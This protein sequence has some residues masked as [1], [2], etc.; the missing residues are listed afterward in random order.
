[1]PPTPL[2][3]LFE[4][5][6]ADN[7]GESWRNSYKA[8]CSQIADIRSG[9]QQLTLDFVKQAWTARNFGPAS[10][11]QARVGEL[12]FVAVAD[13]LLRIT[14]MV[15]TDPSPETLDNAYAKLQQAKD[16]S[17]IGWTP[18]VLT[19]RLM[20]AAAPTRYTSVVYKKFYEPLHKWLR[21]EYGLDIPDIGNWANKDSSMRTSLVAHGLSDTDPYLLN[22]FIWDLAYTTTARPAKKG[23]T[24]EQDAQDEDGADAPR[25]IPLPPALN[26]IYYGPPGTG[27]TYVVRAMLDAHFV[28]RTESISNAQWEESLV[29]EPGWRDVIAAV[30]K[31]LGGKATVPQIRKHS[32]I[33]AKFRCM[34]GKDTSRQQRIWGN[35][36]RHSSLDSTTVNFSTRKPPFLFD[37]LDDAAS[38]WVLLADWE[39]EAPG[40]VE[41]L[42]LFCKGNSAQEGHEKRRYDS[43]T[44]HQSYSY[45]EFVEGI[46]PVLAGEEPGD[47]D[48]ADNLTYRLH[49]G[50]F[51]KI[52]TDARNDPGKRPYALLIDEINRGNISKIFGELIT[53]MEDAKREGEAEVME[54]TLPYS[55]KP[56]SIPSNLYIIGT[57]NT[58]DRSL[59]LMDTALRR[60]FAF[61]RVDPDP[62]LL[63]EKD[64]EG[65]RLDLLLKTINERIEALYDKEHAIGHS[66]LWHVE[67]R[68]SLRLAFRNKILPLLEEYFF[69]DW[70]KIRLVLG[71]NQK[72]ALDLGKYCFLTKED[73]SARLFGTDVELAQPAPRWKYNTEAMLDPKAYIAI[74]DPAAVTERG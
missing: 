68:K 42:R 30:L 34:S 15:I 62:S 60:R 40:A 61:E 58:A 47:E 43:I 70:E 73:R 6:R 59:A 10:V 57:M 44:F 17:K 12:E 32:L 71:D 8:V 46:R 14:E 35:L 69:E 21:E 31:D 67:D 27:K 19:N 53:L 51:K 54:V 5:Y 9:R 64:V 45:E 20:A 55:G 41:L 13:V 72:V 38:T 33:D 63:A 28:T 48:E 25:E 29:K 7:Q 22:T 39:E 16:E 1:M 36:L 4:Q 50:V 52:C 56:F 11:S 3:D 23:Q 26:T 37:K 18:W 24:P 2:R 66:Y 65:V 74:Y 49:N